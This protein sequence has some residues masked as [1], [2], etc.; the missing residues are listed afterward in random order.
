MLRM[1]IVFDQI[2]LPIWRIITDGTVRKHA[3]QHLKDVRI[4]MD[5]L[6]DDGDDEK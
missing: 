2:G 4:N 5:G 3:A 6:E 1:R